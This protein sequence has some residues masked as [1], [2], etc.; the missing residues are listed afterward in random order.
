MWLPYDDKYDVS[1]D[2]EVRHRKSGR[3]TLGSMM[4]IGY[5]KHLIY[6]DT[7]KKQF[8]VHRMVAEKFLPCTDTTNLE[9]DHINRDKSDNR[10]CN[11]RWCSKSINQQNKS[12]ETNTG[13]KNIHCA[14]EVN[15][16]GFRK[17]FKTLEE[18]I[19]ARDNIISST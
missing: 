5:Y 10:A 13:H 12:H 18:A 19:T 1:S 15:M 6:R 17:R 11:L 8:L 3:I 4:K 9:V 7:V 16:P 14:Y 2:G